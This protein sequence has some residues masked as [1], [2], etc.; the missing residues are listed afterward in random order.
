MFLVSGQHTDLVR[1]TVIGKSSRVHDQDILCGQC[2]LVVRQWISKE[3]FF[4]LRFR[5][6]YPVLR[7]ARRRDW[8]DHNPFESHSLA[9]CKIE[10][11]S[12]F[13]SPEFGQSLSRR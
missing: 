12:D 5:K 8:S 13:R 10:R 2:A 7:P 1:R 9:Q 3:I 6:L 11:R 4:L